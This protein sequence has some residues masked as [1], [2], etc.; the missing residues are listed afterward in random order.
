MKFKSVQINM[1]QVS[2][3]QNS[4]KA[5]SYSRLVPNVTGDKNALLPIPLLGI[6]L[7]RRIQNQTLY[8][9]AIKAGFCCNAVEVYYLIPRPCDKMPVLILAF[10]SMIS[11]TSESLKN[12]KSLYFQNFSLNELSMSM[13]NNGV[14]KTLKR[15]CTSKGDHWIKQ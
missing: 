4:H 14:A 8:H 13:D 10:I 2:Y 7:G 6:N 12:K 11:A 3:A 15:I 1:K 9:V 5:V